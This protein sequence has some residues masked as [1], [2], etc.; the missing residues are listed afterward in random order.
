MHPMKKYTNYGKVLAIIRVAATCWLLHALLPMRMMACFRAA[1]EDI[2]NLKGVGPYT[3]AAIASFAYNLPYAV[4]DG[5]VFRVLSRCFGISTPIDSTTGK[6]EFALLANEVLDKENPAQHNQAIMDFGATV[7]KPANPL[8]AECPMQEGCDAYAAKLTNVLPVKEKK[9]KITTRWFT[10]FVF[11]ANGETLVR[12]RT[13]NDMWQE[14]YEFYLVETDSEKLWSQADVQQYLQHHI[15]MEE[16]RN[17][18]IS[19][20][21]SQQLTHQTINAVFIKIKLEQKPQNLTDE[22]WVNQQ[23]LQQLP[24]PKIINAF[25]NS[26]SFPASL[27]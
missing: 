8:C 6:K 25:L 19:P 4:L 13:A 23:Q 5:N 20:M 17:I 1:Y 21:L 15:S 10:Y 7:C 26:T 27:F 12:K 16:P 3:A 11:T 24:F 9:M 22:L 18:Y 2:L 14:L